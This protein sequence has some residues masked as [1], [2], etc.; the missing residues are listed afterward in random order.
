MPA[1]DIHR[2][3]RRHHLTFETLIHRHGADN[4][5]AAQLLV[6]GRRAIHAYVRKQGGDTAVLLP[7]PPLLT[8]AVGSWVDQRHGDRAVVSKTADTL[9]RRMLPFDYSNTPA[10][11]KKSKKRTGQH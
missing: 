7:F 4:V 2:P 9:D 8:D 11:K 3:D 6:Y 5:C 1:T 10:K